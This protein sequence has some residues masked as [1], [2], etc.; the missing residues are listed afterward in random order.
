MTP[1]PDGRELYGNIRMAAAMQAMIDKAVSG[2]FNFVYFE[3]PLSQN[4]DEIVSSPRY[5]MKM[6]EALLDTDEFLESVAPISLNIRSH[7]LNGLSSK[8][9]YEFLADIYFFLSDQ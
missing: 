4:I 9:L 8:S 5:L 6:T 1:G 7:L 2:K 3:T